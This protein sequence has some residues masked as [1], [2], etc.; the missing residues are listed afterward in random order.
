MLIKRI[1]EVKVNSDD[2]DSENSE[3]HY[4]IEK[5]EQYS[6]GMAY[7][8]IGHNY[9]QHSRGTAK[10]TEDSAK[11]YF[12]KDDGAME[13]VEWEGDRMTLEE[14][15]Y[16]KKDDYHDTG[17]TL[18]RSKGFVTNDH[19]RLFKWMHNDTW[20]TLDSLK[21]RLLGNYN[22][23]NGGVHKLNG[24]AKYNRVGMRMLTC[25]NSRDFYDCYGISHLNPDTTSDQQYNKR[26]NAFLPNYS[27]FDYIGEQVLEDWE[28]EQSKAEEAAREKANLTTV[29]D[30]I[31]Q[32][33]G[34]KKSHENYTKQ[35]TDLQEQFA[36][37]KTTVIKSILM[38]QTMKP[39]FIDMLCVE[40]DGYSGE[41]LDN[42]GQLSLPNATGENNYKQSKKALA[43]PSLQDI[44]R[45]VGNI[46]RLKKE[47]HAYTDSNEVITVE[48]VAQAV[49]FVETAPDEVITDLR[50][51]VWEH[52]EKPAVARQDILNRIAQDMEAYDLAFAETVSA[53]ETRALS[54]EIVKAEYKAAVLSLVG[55]LAR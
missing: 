31:P 4:T 46:D 14:K 26:S 25:N 49:S 24:L 8:L 7:R 6:V 21:Q 18:I 42:M 19:F 30:A 11:Y 5:Q 1:V 12:L 23:Y 2:W 40:S 15:A 33:K 32:L 47:W 34:E 3:Y 48:Q 10:A 16:G 50:E 29:M 53:K 22:D 44:A 51:C 41:Y 38:N 17:R 20:Q 54:C 37:L 45:G 9:Y 36:D 39:E 52:R 55:Q 35:I 27:L 13:W 43:S 28:G